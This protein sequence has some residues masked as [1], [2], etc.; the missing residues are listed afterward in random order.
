[1][2]E[3]IARDLWNRLQKLRKELNFEV[4]DKISV[5]IEKNNTI[6]LPLTNNYSYICSETLSESI[7]L[8]DA[9]NDNNKVEVELTDEIKIF[10]IINKI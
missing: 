1:M 9:I 6:T 8:V 4:T 7:I 10:I 5:E 3:G 2:E